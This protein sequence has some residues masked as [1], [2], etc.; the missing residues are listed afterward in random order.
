MC[1]AFFFFFLLAFGT[2]ASSSIRDL[3]L[4]SML[5]LCMQEGDLG[6]TASFADDGEILDGIITRSRGEVRH[7]CSRKASSS[8]A[9]PSKEFTSLQKS[10][11]FPDKV[12]QSKS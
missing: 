2:S 8:T 12:T 4:S 6:K 9:T 3:L 10:S 7:V 5:A 1:K 11:S